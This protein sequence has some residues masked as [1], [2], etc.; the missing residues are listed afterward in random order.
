MTP[1]D[2]FPPSDAL[3]LKRRPWFA[4]VGKLVPTW[5]SRARLYNHSDGGPPD[6]EEMWRDFNRKLSGLFGNGPRGPTPQGAPNTPPDMK[7]AGIGVGLLAGA[8]AMV[9]AGSGFFIVQE[10]EQAVVTAFGE[11]SHLIDAGFSKPTRPSRSPA[12]ARWKLGAAPSLP[13]PACANRRC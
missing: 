6:M 13:P 4:F 1:R 12:C 3:P 2:H 5:L 7:H 11:Y 9:W 8:V 10:G